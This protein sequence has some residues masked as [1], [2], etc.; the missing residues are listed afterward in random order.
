[1]TFGTYLGVLVKE[2]VLL[3]ELLSDQLLLFLVLFLLSS[4]CLGLVSSLREI[5]CPCMSFYHNLKRKG[6]IRDS[7]LL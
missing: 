1:M 5:K 3:H 6:K 7:R 2:Q 4:S